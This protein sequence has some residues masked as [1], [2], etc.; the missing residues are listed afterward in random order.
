MK[1]LSVNI[2]TP[3]SYTLG[4]ISLETS[5]VKSPQNKIYVSL[6]SIEGDVFKSNQ[7]HGTPDA[8]VYAMSGKNYQ[9]WSDFCGKSLPLG[10]LG[11]NL[12]LDT[13]DESDFFLGDEF[14]CGDVKMRVT[15]VRF[16]CSRLNF[17]TGNPKM[18]DEFLNR[19]WP[20]VYFEVLAAGSIK[21]NDDLILKNRLQKQI[22]VLDLYNA[23]RASEK[24]TLSES[25]LSELIASP[26]LHQR[27]KNSLSRR[28][29][30]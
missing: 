19:D 27:Y 12:S 1:I 13:L 8:V 25:Q 24:K 10:H 18:R 28:A 22:S 9:F 5:M 21:P 6:T 26:F 20:G 29:G 17:V 2:G 14:Q 30:G 7:V 16:P 15:G 4:G 3:K 23:L 11:E